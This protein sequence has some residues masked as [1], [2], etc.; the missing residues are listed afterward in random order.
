V[1]PSPTPGAA[2]RAL[3]LLAAALL[4]L[5]APGVAQLTTEQEREWNRPVEP[6]RIAGNVYYVGAAEVASYLVTT[7]AGHFLLDS[8][9]PETVPQILA[10]VERLGFD[11]RDVEL[12]LNSHAHYD[13]AGGIAEL[14]ARTGASIL[15][16]AGDV[17]LARRGGR[18]D[19]AFGDRFG[20][21]PFTA[22]RIVADGEAVTLGGVTMTAH[23]TPG[24]TR[25]CTTWTTRVEEQG[26]PLDVLFLCSV[27]AP[28]YRLVGNEAYPAILADY[29][30]TFR[31]LEA[32]PVDV[33]LANHGSF[34]DLGAKRE[35]LRAAP[36]RNPFVDPAGYR[37]N[38]ARWKEELERKAR[39]QEDR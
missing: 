14:K 16:S 13:H 36:A 32:L 12:L 21:P 37:R 17:E 38:L 34:F 33:F 2:L 8:G 30:E 3:A 1:D 7:P 10:N 28:G 11:P 22:D 23:V 29:R 19:F 24:H 5:A 26:A 6:F 20:Y 27:T 18:G 9:F 31:R 4:A 39:E 25:G 35:A 15:L